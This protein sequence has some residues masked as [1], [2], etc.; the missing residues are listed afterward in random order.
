MFYDHSSSR[1]ATS[2]F[3]DSTSDFDTSRIIATKPP[4]NTHADLSRARGLNFKSESFIYI[5][6][7]C[8]QAARALESPHIYAGSPEPSAIGNKSCMLV[9]FL[10]FHESLLWFFQ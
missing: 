1:R 3:C 7:M 9:Y 5:H 6:T 8:M 4:L 10:F 2:K